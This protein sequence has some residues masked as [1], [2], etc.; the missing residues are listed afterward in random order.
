MRRNIFMRLKREYTLMLIMIVIFVP[1]ISNSVVIDPITDW[2]N[3]GLYGGEIYDIAIAPVDH[4][5]MFAGTYYGDGLFVTEDGG[6]T[7]KAVITGHEGGEYDG[8][9]TFRNTA[10]FAVKIAPSNHNTIWAA[11]NYWVEKSLDG[12]GIWTHIENR[13]MQQDCEGCGGSSDGFRFCWALAIDP[14]DPNIVYVGTGGPYGSMANGAIYKTTNGGITWTKLREFDY[15]V[16]DIEI[17]VDGS[18][19]RIIWA[20]TNSF[21]SGWVYDSSVYR[22]LCGS[23]GDITWAAFSPIG[24]LTYDIAMKP[25]DPEVVLVATWF[26]IIR[27][28]YDTG[29]NSFTYTTPIGWEFGKNIRALAFDLA[30]TSYNTIYV[31]GFGSKLGKITDNGSSAAEWWDIGLQFQTIESHPS[32]LGAL[33]AGELSR[34]VYKINYGSLACNAVNTGINAM[35]VFDLAVDPNDHSHFIAGTMAGVYEKQDSGQWVAMAPLPFTK[36][37]SV[38]FDPSDKDGSSFF[39]GIEGQVAKTLDHG[40]NW[41]LSNDLGRYFI[42]DIAVSANGSLLFATGEKV[43]AGGSGAIFKS[44]DSAST[45]VQ[46]FANDTF[47]FN[48]VLIDPKNANHI[49][50]GSGNFYAPKAMGNL[51]ESSNAGN[52]WTV[53]GLTNVVVN[54]ILIDP[55]DSNIIYAGCGY[56]SGTNTP[57]YKSIDGGATWKPSYEGMPGAP[58]HHGVWGSGDDVFVLHHLGSTVKGGYDDMSILHYCSPDWSNEDIPVSDILYG[59]W[60]TSA[61]NVF[62]VGE[63]GVIIHRDASAWSQMSNDATQDLFGIYGTS[64]NHV[65]AVGRSGTILHY[66]GTSWS[67]MASGTSRDLY[68][69]WGNAD[70]NFYAVGASGTVLH[71]DGS[72]WQEMESNTYTRL[73]AVWG[74][75]DGSEVFSVGY[76]YRDDEDNLSYGIFRYDGDKW[77]K[78]D[79]PEVEKGSGKLHGIWGTSE[80]NIFAVGDGGSVL[81]YDGMTW[82]IMDSNT[83]NRLYG[84]WVNSGSKAFAVGLY[85]TIISYETQ[86]TVI[87]TGGFGTVWNPV[88]DLGSKF[89]S[90]G[91]WI[92]YA[93]TSRQGI[94]SSPNSGKSWVR[95]K[96]PGYDVYALETGSVFVATQG[97]VHQY[98]GLGWIFGE[99]KDDITGLGIGKAQVKSDTSGV[100]TECSEAGLYM[101]QLQAGSH[102]LTASAQGYKPERAMDVPVYGSEATTV[103]F[104]LHDPVITLIAGQGGSVVPTAGNYKFQGGV[105]TVQCGGWVVLL[106]IPD[107][108]FGVDA[109]MLDGVSQGPV[110]ALTLQDVKEDVTLKVSFALNPNACM[111]DFFADGDVDGQD[112]SFYASAGISAME[113]EQIAAAFGRSDCQ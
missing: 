18:G 54:A 98:T 60:G 103:N 97:G 64:G 19:D 13:T 42:N 69:V 104:T 17:G 93:S 113:L 109:V 71:Y 26:G 16:I 70:D 63:S 45:F 20:A 9:A 101:M 95:I 4:N 92:I 32:Q 5:K 41:T 57:L 10:T 62:A 66:D 31:A 91:N 23:S 108:G 2:T 49:L 39:A 44:T 30:D 47:D 15:S 55:S 6:I 94:F 111:G 34:G 105:V 21:G 80:T 52:T 25:S 36:A 35:I 72:C 110:Q 40:L 3:L 87:N 28:V 53:T 67:S 76:A 107:P 85:G 24:T 29:E 27:L 38:A 61:S 22:G 112:L 106:I 12:G 77:C 59:I 90:T 11:H 102:H 78:M 75:E 7:W 50:A 84:V 86:W 68:G 74:L 43:G 89:D 33:F 58:V 8:E 65:F 96:S 100:W 83:E 99:V 73:T 46:V 37:F 48:T 51:Y 14:I 82:S 81:N 88:T 1:Q 56:S 79:T